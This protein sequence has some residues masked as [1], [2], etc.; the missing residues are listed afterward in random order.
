MK[1]ARPSYRPGRAIPLEIAAIGL[2]AFAIAVYSQTSNAGNSY[3]DP[4]K[5]V[6]RGEDTSIC[7]PPPKT[8][9]G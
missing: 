6:T 7:G 3:A 8:T 9:L 1:L 2:R 5:T 4:T